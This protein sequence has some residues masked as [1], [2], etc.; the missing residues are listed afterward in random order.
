MKSI[1]FLLS[2][3]ALA[4]GYCLERHGKICE[5]CIDTLEEVKSATTNE[6]VEKLV[7]DVATSVCAFAPRAHHDK[8][9][10]FVKKAMTNNFDIIREFTE[11]WGPEDM[12]QIV[13][14]CPRHVVG[15]E[16]KVCTLCSDVVGVVRY[17]STD[18]ALE[19][20]IEAYVETACV[21]TGPLS[22]MCKKTVDLIVGETFEVI[23]K[24][25]G[26]MEDEEICQN[27]HLCKS[28]EGLISATSTSTMGSMCDACTATV[29]E[30]EDILAMDDLE[31]ILEDISGVA[32]SLLPSKTL[33]GTCTELTQNVL[34]ET[35]H[36]LKQLLIK[37][38]GKTICQIAH[39]CKKEQNFVSGLE[40]ASPGPMC[41]LC[42]DSLH[43]SREVLTDPELETM[44][45]ADIKFACSFTGLFHKACEDYSDKFTHTLFDQ[46]R[47]TFDKFDDHNTCVL[48][49]F[50]ADTNA[51]TVCD[52]CK[53]GYEEV[54]EFLTSDSLKAIVKDEV[55]VACIVFGPFK[56]ICV[57]EA[58]KVVDVVFNVFHKLDDV[59]G[60]GF[61]SKLHLCKKPALV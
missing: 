26:S 29:Q 60:E 36:F 32:C 23:R 50:C 52:I 47:K 16:G 22:S 21:V 48:F 41:L 37:Y 43:F 25:F 15:V 27:L 59:T 7:T 13:W 30:V 31:K 40:D 17:L 35:F 10:Q 34:E 58:N 18:Q 42:E 51:T 38:D 57:A 28:E 3:V 9:E 53:D 56:R 14:L 49:D 46:V 11:L 6:Q 5:L 33:S 20:M 55:D 39:L 61:C 24:V 1:V 54:K 12:C 45:N 2:F 44:V 19:T 4:S 8:C